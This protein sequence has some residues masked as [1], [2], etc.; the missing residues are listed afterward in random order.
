MIQEW[1]LNWSVDVIN[2]MD[3]LG[4]VNIV[5]DWCAQHAVAMS[6]ALI[7]IRARIVVIVVLTTA[8]SVLR[9]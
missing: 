9:R 8:Q 1:Y 4:H 7:V 5:I 6:I 2:A 3:V